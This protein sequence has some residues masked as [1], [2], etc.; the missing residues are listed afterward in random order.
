MVNVNVQKDGTSVVVNCAEQ[1]LVRQ[2][3]C[4][5]HGGRQSTALGT[6]T[7][8]GTITFM[9]GT[10]V[11]GTGKLVAGAAT[12]TFGK[13]A[14]GPHSITAVYTG[15]S[16]FLPETSPALGHTVIAATYASK[17]I[18]STSA[19]RSSIGQPLTLTA[20]VENT[21]RIIGNPTGQVA[22]MDGA[23]LLAMVR[24]RNG[25]A[26]W[27]TSSLPLGPNPISVHYGGDHA[28]SPSTSAVLVETIVP[29]STKTQA[30]S[31][32][33]RRSLAHP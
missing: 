32:P 25:K 11:V 31:A 7:A 8:T 30:S 10:T 9:D 21:T 20:T 14:I 26:V 23:K 3:G 19:Q 12:A 4:R 16:N 18:L 22:F 15:D 27:A 1:S 13:L 33:D 6:G 17:T 29:E 24:L 5:V 2:P 28:F